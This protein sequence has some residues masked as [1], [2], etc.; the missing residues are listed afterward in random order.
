VAAKQVVDGGRATALD[1]VQGESRQARYSD[2][3]PPIVIHINN[4]W[5]VV[6]VNLLEESRAEPR[7]RAERDLAET[8]AE[9]GQRRAVGEA[10]ADAAGRL[11]PRRRTGQQ[12]GGQ[13]Q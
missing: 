9:L 5:V 13:S 2:N 4:R 1:V 8:G 10:G 11:R 3:A 6:T 7:E 12:P